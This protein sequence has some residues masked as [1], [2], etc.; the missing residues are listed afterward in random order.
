M[1]TGGFELWVKCLQGDKDAL[2]HMLKY[3]KEDVW[4]LEELY[5]ELRPWIRSH[6]NLAL[7]G[8]TVDGSCT[9][10][11]CK[12][13]DYCGTYTTMVNSFKSFRCRECGAIMRSRHTEV[14]GNMKANLLIPTAR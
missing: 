11:G 8:E 4:G 9:R 14:R 7:F 13:M 2:A 10:C 6:P 3:N 5:T 12:E 1:D